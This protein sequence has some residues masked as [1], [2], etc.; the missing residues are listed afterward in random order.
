MRSKEEAHDYRYFP[1]PDLGRPGRRRRLDRRGRVRACRSCPARGGRVSWRRTASRPPTPRRSFR[2]ASSRTIS[3]GPSPRALRRSSSANWVTG[4]LLRWMKERKHSAE[5]AL[6]FAVSP[7]RLAG[8]LRLLEAGQISAAS[9]KEVLEAM[10]ESAAGAEDIVKERGL[11][12]RSDAGALDAH[13][14]GDRLRQPLP[15]RPLPLG[16]DADLRLVRR[17]GHEEDRRP[18]R[19]GPRARGAGSRAGAARVIQLFRVSKDYGRFRHALIDVSCN[20]RAGRVRVSDRPL[21]RRQVH[22]PEAPLPRGVPF[23]RTDPRQRAQHRRPAA[24]ADPVLPAHGGRGLP[25]LQADRPQDGLR[26][27]GLRAERARA[28]ARRAEA[29]RLPGPEARRPPPPDERLPGGA[30]RRRAAARRDRAG[31]RQRAD[32]PSGRR[33]HGQPRPRA[34]RGDHAALRRDQHPRDDGARRHPRLRADPAHGQARPDAR[35]RPPARAHAAARCAATSCAKCP[36]C[37][38]D[39][40]PPSGG[41]P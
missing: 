3:S 33:A 9:A 6:S 36:S 16:Q 25:G 30:V 23:R 41:E 37:R 32:A 13:R 22:V 28:A 11:G 8:L 17:P 38:W 19:P 2:R 15:G 18:G 27:R 7:D 10:M 1:E 12:K 5:D 31:D 14:R 21:G 39:S 24:V 34:R 26:K 35:A 4:E 20:D 40:F 29:A